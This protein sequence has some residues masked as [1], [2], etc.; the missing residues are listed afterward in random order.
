MKLK[1]LLGKTP[2][3][4]RQALWGLALIAPNTIGLFF[5]F[6]LPI[7]ASFATS[8]Y[9]WNAF[10]PAVYVGTQ[11]FEEL[12]HDK[13]FHQAIENTFQLLGLV[14]PIELVLALAVAMLLNQKLRGQVIFRTAYFLPVVTSTVAASIVWT[15]IF[16]PRYGL[17]GNLLEPFGY[18]DTAWLTRP[19]LVLYPIAVVSIWQR[20]GFDMIL[21]LAGLQ[22]IPRTLYEAA[23]MDGANRFQQFRHVTLPMLSPTTFLVLVLAIINNLQTFDQVFIMTARTVRGGVGGS[24]RTISLYLYER[25]F[26]QSD[27]GDASAIA[28]VL[29]ILILGITVLQL[30]LQ[31]RWVYY[32]SEEG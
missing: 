14:V 5:F 7:L 8:F 32:E 27:Y 29:F 21:F 31:K 15:W 2:L 24:A 12:Y 3:A 25:G 13:I 11:N 16:Q 22:A 4:R 9:Q 6:G 18:R 28:L 20:L 1:N 26:L 30:N 19:N 17:M 10:K 23:K